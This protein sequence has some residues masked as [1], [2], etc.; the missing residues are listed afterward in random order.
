[1]NLITRLESTEE[2]LSFRNHLAKT[3]NEDLSLN[4]K[5]R[6]LDE[7]AAHILGVANWNTVLG[8]MSKES[9]EEKSTLSEVSASP[10]FNPAINEH[11][12]IMLMYEFMANTGKPH[13]LAMF[14]QSAGEMIVGSGKQLSAEEIVGLFYRNNNTVTLV[15]ILMDLGMD[16]QSFKDRDYHEHPEYLTSGQIDDAIA[17]IMDSSHVPVFWELESYRHDHQLAKRLLDFVE[18]NKL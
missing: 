6:K 5:Q 2:A 3:L 12:M 11:D 17:C 10:R 8:Q 14:K 1:M 9:T 15:K 18:K 13:F 16:E 7:L 4:L